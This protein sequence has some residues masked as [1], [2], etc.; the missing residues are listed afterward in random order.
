MTKLEESAA[1]AGVYYKTTHW[2]EWIDSKFQCGVWESTSGCDSHLVP[3]HSDIFS[4]GYLLQCLM[5]GLELILN[6]SKLL[7]L[8]I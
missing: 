2:I 5:A 1:Y 8:K 7:K 6:Q 4:H 3:S